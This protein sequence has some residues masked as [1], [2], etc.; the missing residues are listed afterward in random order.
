MLHSVITRYPMKSIRRTRSLSHRPRVSGLGV[1][2]H[3]TL[4]KSFSFPLTLL[5]SHPVLRSMASALL[6]AAVPIVLLSSSRLAAGVR[7]PAASDRR[8]VHEGGAIFPFLP[9]LG[10]G[11][12]CIPGVRP[13]W[14]RPIKPALVRKLF[15]ALFESL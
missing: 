2:V 15:D 9:P 8:G 6:T 1:G 4:F 13:I 3:R 5:P 7:L 10:P 11:V 12:L 14:P